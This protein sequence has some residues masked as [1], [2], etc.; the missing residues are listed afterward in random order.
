MRSGNTS[1][2]LRLI[3]VSS[4]GAPRA[5]VAERRTLPETT[6]VPIRFTMSTIARE[7]RV[8][9]ALEPITLRMR[10]WRSIS[11]CGPLATPPKPLIGAPS[12]R[13][14]L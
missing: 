6:H 8:S 3:N 14:R 2:F 11:G 5:R 13:I 1:G 4:P 7:S 10:V 9:P 12:G